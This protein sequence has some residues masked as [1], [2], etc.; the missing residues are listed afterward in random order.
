[1]PSDPCCRTRRLHSKTGSECEAHG[2]DARRVWTVGQFT[3]STDRRQGVAQTFS[4]EASAHQCKVMNAA[5]AKRMDT[6]RSHPGSDLCPSRKGLGTGQGSI[7]SQT[8]AQAAPLLRRLWCAR[9]FSI[10]ALL[11]VCAS[12]SLWSPPPHPQ[13][14][15]PLP[16]RP[17]A[18]VQPLLVS[19][20]QPSIRSYRIETLK[21]TGPDPYLSMTGMRT[22]PITTSQIRP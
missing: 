6:E 3:H 10:C 18:K 2:R 11:L 19:P 8:E 1:M 14:V 16:A 21:I 15:T 7:R 9:Q 4:K 17:T 5:Q 22:N 20:N 12:C 13:A